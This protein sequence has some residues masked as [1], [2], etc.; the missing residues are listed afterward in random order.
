MGPRGQTNPQAF[1][2]QGSRLLVYS[3]RAQAPRAPHAPIDSGVRPPGPREALLA[4]GYTFRLERL[5]AR[6]TNRNITLIGLACF[7]EWESPGSSRLLGQHLCPAG[8]SC[9][10][11]S[12]P[13]HQ[14]HQFHT[15]H[16]GRQFCL[17]PQILEYA[18]PGERVSRISVGPSAPHVWGASLR[19][20]WLWRRGS[21]THSGHYLQARI[22]TMSW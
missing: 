13:G 6:D 19:A 7:W 22:P 8:R 16:L 4:G 15:L 20:R 9:Q 21:P 11:G 5:D 14:A 1:G 17:A 3:T 18:P 2:P 10:C 12:P